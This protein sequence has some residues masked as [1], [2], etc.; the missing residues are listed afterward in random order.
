MGFIKKKPSLLKNIAEMKDTDYSKEPELNN[1]YQRLL[2]GKRQFEDILEK[3]MRVVMQISSLDITLEHHTQDVTEIAKNVA[4]SA[5]TI[6]QAATETTHVTAEVTDQHERLTDTIIQAAGETEDVYAKIVSGQKEL[7]S[8]RDLSAQSI[9]ISREMQ[10][11]MNEL[12][13]VI[14][15]MND[16]IAGINSISSQT[17]LLALN[18]SIE[19]ARA[20]EAGRGFAVVAEEIRQLAEETQ[21]L[22][23]NMG[24]FVEG[25]RNA[26]EKSTKSAT[27]TIESLDAMTEK[28][29]LVWEINDENLQNISKVNDSISALAGFSEEISSS[30]TTM[31]NQSANIQDKCEML[32]DNSSNMHSVSLALKDTMKP[33]MDIESVMD[34]MAKELGKMSEDAFFALQNKEFAKYVENAIKAHQSW[35]AN[36]K[37]MVT[38][39]TVLPLQL[40][41]TKCGFG[42]FY[43]AMA[44]KNSAVKPTWD[45]L[46][47]KHKKFHGY[48]AEVIKALFDENYEKADQIYQEAEDYSKELIADLEKIKKIE[49]MPE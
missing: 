16:V 34:Q 48:G 5:E 12:F 3:N 8:I 23:G 24:G 29:G 9:Q 1:I 13:D 26:S 22:T 33:I 41:D 14:N 31:E 40:D 44:P 32:K 42:H 38:E 27:N 47:A 11:D 45:A 21:K 43:Y 49:E 25:I 20:G 15:R 2:K 17:N 46:A 35:L 4:D 19:A 39:R 10:E 28:I 30:M 6:Y 7:T 36:L 37:K 18:A